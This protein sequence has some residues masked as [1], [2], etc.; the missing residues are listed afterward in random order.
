MWTSLV[1]S[2]ISDSQIRHQLLPNLLIPAFIG[3]LHCCWEVLLAVTWGW[4]VIFL[5]LAHEFVFVTQ[6][7]KH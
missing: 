5:P 4:A 2:G 6:T 3:I 7:V 1:R